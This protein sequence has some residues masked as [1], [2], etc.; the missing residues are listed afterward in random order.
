MVVIVVIV[1]IAIVLLFDLISNSNSNSSSSTSSS[2]LLVGP[3]LGIAMAC[4]CYLSPT[5]ETSYRLTPLGFVLLSLFRPP[6]VSYTIH[7]QNTCI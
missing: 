3:P 6:L 5:L 2:S 1:V 4:R 7:A